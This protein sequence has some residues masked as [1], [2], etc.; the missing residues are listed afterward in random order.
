MPSLLLELLWIFSN[1]WEHVQLLKRSL[2]DLYMALPMKAEDYS[3]HLRKP[4][5]VLH[6][7]HLT[8]EQVTVP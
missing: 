5:R 2:L 3:Q 6:P 7:N 4:V 8:G 1:E